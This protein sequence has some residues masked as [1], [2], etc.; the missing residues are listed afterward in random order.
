MICTHEPLASET[1]SGLHR[2]DCMRHRQP[3]EFVL[4]CATMVSQTGMPQIIGL[5]DPDQVDVQHYTGIMC[6]RTFMLRLDWWT[7]ETV[8]DSRTRASARTGPG[9]HGPD[10]VWAT[11]THSARHRKSPLASTCADICK[12]WTQPQAVNDSQGMLSATKNCKTP[13]KISHLTVRLGRC[14]CT[15]HATK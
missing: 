4:T 8:P 15:N 12:P 14:Q 2:C 1:G 5:P 13:F 9:L 6:L 7:R 10:L 11:S 3:P